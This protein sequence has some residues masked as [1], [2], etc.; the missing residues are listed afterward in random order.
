MRC[1]LF[2][3]N[4]RPSSQLHLLRCAPDHAREKTHARRAVCCMQPRPSQVKRKPSGQ[5]LYP[6]GVMM[7][8]SG[9]LPLLLLRYALQ[10]CSACFFWVPATNPGHWLFAKCIDWPCMVDLLS[11]GGDF[12]REL[13]LC[14]LCKAA[15]S[16]VLDAPS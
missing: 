9:T 7:R 6:L 13:E 4:V 15:L 12:A 1:R 10:C 8:V 16:L 14:L 11:R 2:C 5:A 3:C